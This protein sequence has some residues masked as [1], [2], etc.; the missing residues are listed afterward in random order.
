MRIL[1]WRWLLAGHLALVPGGLGTRCGMYSPPVREGG[2]GG[3]R[4]EG[5]GR[6]GG[7]GRMVG[8]DG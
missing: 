6:E 1:F 2:G 4:G 7:G 5:G 3:G 8:E